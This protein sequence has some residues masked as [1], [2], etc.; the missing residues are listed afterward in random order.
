[1]QR[2]GSSL[3]RPLQQRHEGYLHSD[4]LAATLRANREVDV[5][6]LQMARQKILFC[7]HSPTPFNQIAD[8]D[9]I[10]TD[11]HQHVCRVQLVLDGE[12]L[13]LGYLSWSTRHAAGIRFQAAE[14]KES[15]H[16]C[17]TCNRGSIAHG[18]LQ[19]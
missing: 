11:Y 17:Y 6:L 2:D 3:G 16:C 14:K 10:N 4:L 9:V 12:L 8:D 13:Q 15:S 18:N 19:D 7:A 1:V 5:F